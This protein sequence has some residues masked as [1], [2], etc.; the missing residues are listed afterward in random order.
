MS[1]LSLVRYYLPGAGARIGVAQDGIVFDATQR[2][3]SVGNWLR[4]SAGRV[5]AAIDELQRFAVGGRYAY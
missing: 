1:Q 5:Q 2:V 3:G 4:A